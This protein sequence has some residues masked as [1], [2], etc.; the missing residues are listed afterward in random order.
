MPPEIE[1]T[2]EDLAQDMDDLKSQDVAV[3][4]A[5]ADETVEA[6][7]SDAVDVNV[8]ADSLSIV[9]DVVEG[10]AK[11][12]TEASSAVTE[13]SERKDASAPAKEQ[14]DENYTDV[15]FH[16]HPRF[17]QILGRLKTAETD[18]THYRN[19]QSFIDQQGLNAQEAADLLTIGGLMKT[20]PAEA[21][22]RMKPVVQKV[23]VAAGEVIPD[24]LKAMVQAGEMS[25]EAAFE[26]SRSRAMAQST[27]ARTAWERQRSE[28][29]QRNDAASAVQNSV[30]SWEAE[31]KQRDPNFDA[32]LPLI[33]RE[34][35]WLQAKEGRPNTP[36]GVRAQ[37]EKAYNAV[38]ASYVAPAPRQRRP[39]VRPITGGQV[40][41][42]VRPEINS[43]EDAIAAV[44]ARRAG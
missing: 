21:W 37:L 32:K 27:Q 26:V 25:R 12:E 43:T 13:E 24:D 29:R 31:R 28:E 42:S 1:D 3:E 6:K 7:S 35:T 8:E 41:G 34:V 2:T 4:T 38:S 39:A 19:V 36:E 11:A 33:E 14:D 40:N 15:P 18:A 9:R 10:K 44:I 23:L 22:K 30:T 20:D 16:K 5:E 17:Q